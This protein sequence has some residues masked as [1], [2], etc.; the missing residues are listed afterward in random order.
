MGAN[1]AVAV[2]GL[3]DEAIKNNANESKL[4]AI[5]SQVKELS[6]KFPMYGGKA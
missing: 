5:A 4:Q 1:E 6:K 3:I 2:A